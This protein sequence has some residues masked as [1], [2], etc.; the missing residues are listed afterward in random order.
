MGLS[1]TYAGEAVFV[2][3]VNGQPGDIHTTQA[4]QL[5]AKAFDQF[6]NEYIYL[7]GVANCVEGFAVTFDE[8]GV[9]TA[10]AANA[11]GPVAYATAAIVANDFGWFALAGDILAK[12]AA[13]CA[14]NAMV[15]REGADGVV[16]DGR[17]AG[18]QIYHT[19]TRAATSG[20]A[21]VSK[22]QVACGGG[23]V[24]DIYGS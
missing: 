19:I 5:G 4:N 21:A 11:V 20:S 2:T 10:L 1:T 13:N 17:A 18:D 22:I 6:G 24:D 16:G 14:D 23:F 7:K 12:V 8:A 3:P 9:T 15:G